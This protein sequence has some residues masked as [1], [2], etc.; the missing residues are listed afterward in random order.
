M[1]LVQGYA[2]RLT[3]AMEQFVVPAMSAVRTDDRDR[4][5]EDDRWYT[6][7]ETAFAEALAAAAVSDEAIRNAVDLFAG[8]VDAFN[9]GQFHAL[10]RGAYGVDIIRSEPGI[11]ALLA[12]WEAENLR[13]I[14]SI[15]AQYVE[16]LQSRIVSAVE[17]GE[18][19]RSLTATVRQSYPLPMNRAE[20]IARDQ[21]GKLNG[22]LTRYRQTNVGIVEYRWRGT[23]DARERDAHV[24]REGR[25]YAWDEPPD[26]GHPGQPIRCR[27][28]AEPVLPDLDD[29]DALIVH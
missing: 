8:R 7:M 13:L 29:L 15:P 1:R 2:K 22:R 6:A 4:P 9:S 10:L 21:I 17:R 5:P 23:L 16:S 11:Q 19:L 3:D 24:D 20:L 14:K 18:S 12:I 25:V 28:W 27:C 26:D